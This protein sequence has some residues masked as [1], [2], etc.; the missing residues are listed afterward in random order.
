MP[1]PVGVEKVTV[2][3]GQPLALPDGTWIKGTLTFTGPDLGVVPEDD[4][5]FGGGKT[6][7]LV[8][9]DF[10][11]QLVANDATGINPTG[12]TYTVT[13]DFENA[14]NWTRYVQLLKAA[15]TVKLA[16]V[17]VPDPVAGTYTVLLDQAAADARYLQPATAAAAYVSSRPGL[18][19][20]R[21]L[22]PLITQKALYTSGAVGGTCNL[23]LAQTSTPTTGFVKYAPSPV[24]LSGSGNTQDTYGPFTYSA[25]EIVQS[26]QSV[27]FVV[28]TSIDPHTTAN[29]Q[30]ALSVAW[31]TDADVFQV[32]LLPQATTDAVRLFIDG[33]PVQDKPILLS[34]IATEGAL[35]NSH[36]LTVNLGSSSPRRVRIEM[37]NSRF[38]G[39][40]QSPSYDMW[41]V[42][43]NGPKVA[44][45]GD[46]TSGGSNVNIGGGAGTW[47]NYCCDLLGW[48]NRW[49]QSRG[50]T[51]FI[52][53]NSPYTT[54][55]NR[56]ALDIVGKGFDLV[57]VDAGYNDAN[58]DQTAF[59]NAVSSTI[60]QIKAGLPTA[61]VIGIGCY[62]TQGNWPPFAASPVATPL[63]TSVTKDTWQRTVF[64]QLGIPY[65]SQITG[66]IRDASW[67]LV[68]TIGP[69][70]TGSG[71]VSATTG[72]G[73]ADRFIGDNAGTPDVVHPTDAGHKA[74][75]LW[76]ATALR[77]L[78]AV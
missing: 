9:G 66:E 51:G 30:G 74:K 64:Q 11:V 15:P 3:A 43:L 76:M 33:V 40:F 27:N 1:L 44:V 37:L 22:P 70:V 24:P 29:P 13:S 50:G 23:S 48:E 65:I 78:M 28:S 56:A 20:R 57:I 52:T 53:T 4:F 2:T 17:L 38:G 54:L 47:F 68:D 21:D 31:G 41:K 5:T 46:S 19:R 10:T 25:D 55:P 75:A 35:G 14:P 6:V 36:L 7:L 62:T 67:N 59:Q 26:A 72:F 8:D 18:Y 39:V 69:W 32:R 60:S 42:G 63:A 73:T 61:V 71:K 77:K 45:L 34:S 12:G 58:T 49:N 16:D